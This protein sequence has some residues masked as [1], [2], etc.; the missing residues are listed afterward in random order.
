MARTWAGM[1]SIRTFDSRGEIR[2]TKPR[3]RRGGQSVPERPRKGPSL[4]TRQAEMMHLAGTG[5]LEM[6]GQGY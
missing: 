2:R 3:R 5:R 4:W 6:G 1:L